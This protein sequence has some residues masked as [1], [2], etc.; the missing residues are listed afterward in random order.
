MAV[1]VTPER[2]LTIQAKIEALIR[3][4]DMLASGN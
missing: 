2:R 3:K 4:Y 1:N